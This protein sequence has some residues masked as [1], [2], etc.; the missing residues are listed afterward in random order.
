MFKESQL[1]FPVW[2]MWLVSVMLISE[3]V[4]MMLQYVEV[5]ILCECFLNSWI[6]CTHKL[7]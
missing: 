3:S 1:S 5:L 2:A 6:V 7:V 4:M